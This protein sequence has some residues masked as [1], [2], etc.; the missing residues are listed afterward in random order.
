MTIEPSAEA[1]FNTV[2]AHGRR[3]APSMR[4]VQ[5]EAQAAERAR[6]RV[7]LAA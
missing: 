1:L 2:I 4:E 7:L 6:R 5:R 3:G